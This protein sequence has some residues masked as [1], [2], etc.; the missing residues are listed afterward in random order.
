MIYY[1]K[2]VNQTSTKKSY[3][4]KVSMKKNLKKDCLDIFKAG[5]SAVDPLCAVK[6]AV[7]VDGDLLSLPDHT[8]NLSA[9][10]N[11]Y[12][13]GAGKASAF[14]ALALEELLGERVTGGLVIVKYG[15]GADLKKVKVIEGGHPVPDENGHKGAR[16]L[17]DLA[18]GF[19]KN[20]LVFCVVSGG[21]SALL[22]LPAAG[23]SLKDKQDTTKALLN[24]GAPIHDINKI[25]KHLSRIKG[26]GLAR[27]VYPAT[28]I[29]LIISDVIGN[30]LDIIASGP[31][32]PDASTFIECKKILERYDLFPFIPRAVRS[33]L[34]KGVRGETPE[35]PKPGNG[36][37]KKTFNLIIGSNIQCLEAAEKKAQTMGYNTMLLSSFTAGEARETAKVQ[38]AILKE[39]ITSGRPIP[40]PACIISGG[41]TTVTLRGTG[42]GGRNQEFVLACG[43]EIAGW[44]GAAV[45][46]AGTDG[47]DGPTEVAG[48]YADW[49]TVK[50]A[51]KLGLN[52][53][54]YLDDNDSFNFFKH[55]NDLI[56]TGPTKTNVMDLIV[57][58]AT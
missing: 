43:I 32:V 7:K 22:P 37:F 25:R 53:Y 38:A 26:G 45:F 5:V 12:V 57:L 27:A 13:V 20:D 56:I 15:H 8:V 41:E 34:L 35:T 24:C 11:I 33:H 16:S 54:R 51:E 10:K 39:T 2:T 19:G 1:K 29:S 46:S 14:M 47:T 48:A 28:L 9:F 3:Q 17:I 40:R 30:D 44:K 6:K 31:T 42:K 23:I 55:L 18:A 58:L 52:P 50:R 36:I 21:G 4:K 49:K